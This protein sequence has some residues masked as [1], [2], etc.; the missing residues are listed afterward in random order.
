MSP[1]KCP[2]CR[3]AIPAETGFAPFC[4][5]RCK[6]LDLGA[7]AAEKYKIA[8]EPVLLEEVS[9]EM[10]EDLE[11]SGSEKKSPQEDFKLH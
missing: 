11:I 3:Q 10:G 8:A 2:Q 6:L 7:W 4:S 1:R 5:E 9:K